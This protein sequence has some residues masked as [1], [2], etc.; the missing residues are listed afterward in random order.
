MYFVARRASAPP[1]VSSRLGQWRRGE[2]PTAD[3]N[4]APLAQAPAAPDG[5][6]EFGRRCSCC[7]GRSGEFDPIKYQVSTRAVLIA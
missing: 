5:A 7:D 6:L 4:E 3:Y 2:N 1:R